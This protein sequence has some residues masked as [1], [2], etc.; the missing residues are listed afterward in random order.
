MLSGNF[1]LYRIKKY[2]LSVSVPFFFFFFWFPISSLGPTFISLILSHDKLSGVGSQDRI[3]FS[4]F[5][6]TIVVETLDH[7]KSF[8]FLKF[9]TLHN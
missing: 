9:C 1:A 7:K 2:V 5:F 8:I 3:P 6:F 4:A